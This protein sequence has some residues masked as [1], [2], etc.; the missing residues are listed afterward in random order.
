VLAE[1]AG[2]QMK[3]GVDAERNPA[4]GHQA[5]SAVHQHRFPDLDLR[6]EGA[7]DL[8]RRGLRRYHFALGGRRTPIEDSAR[9]QDHA[10][11]AD[12]GDPA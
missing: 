6:I 3:G 7:H 8:D 9:R 5:S 4:A 11:G 10:A 12:R 2:D 1:Q